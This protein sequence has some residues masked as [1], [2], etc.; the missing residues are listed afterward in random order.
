MISQGKGQT[1]IYIHVLRY[2]SEADVLYA[3]IKEKQTEREREKL[4]VSMEKKS[5]I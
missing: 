1:Q 5:R 2:Y 3:E 4:N